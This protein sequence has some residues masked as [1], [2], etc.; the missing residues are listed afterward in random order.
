MNHFLLM[1]LYAAML[2][3]FFATL[4]RRERKAQIRLFL[5]IFGSLLLGAIALGWLLY[6]LPTGPPAPI[7]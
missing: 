4:W 6:F 5:Q 7:P 3:V 1:T 2:G